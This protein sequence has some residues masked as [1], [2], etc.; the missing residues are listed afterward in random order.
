MSLAV[1]SGRALSRDGSIL[2]RDLLARLRQAHGAQVVLLVAPAGYGK[3]SFLAQWADSPQL[4][5]EGVQSV[6]VALEPWHDDPL[7]LMREI[8]CA[9]RSV[10]PFAQDLYADLVR[11]EQPQAAMRRLPA[12]A[13]ALE[14]RA[15]PTLLILDDLQSLGSTTALQVVAT[16]AEH[17]PDGTRLALASRSRPDLPLGRLRAHRALVELGAHDLAMSTPEAT[18]VLER[19]GV[20]LDA[21]RMSELMARSEGWPAALYLATLSLREAPDQAG[22]PASRFSGGD[23][24][25]AEFLRDEFLRHLSPAE[26]ELLVQSSVCEVVSAP[27]CDALIAAPSASAPSPQFAPGDR[28]ARQ[29]SARLLER[30]ARGPLPFEA[31][32]RAHERYR[33]HPLLRDALLAELGRAGP[34]LL[35]LAHARARAWYAAHGDTD[36]AITHAIAAGDARAAG[37][38][39]WEHLPDYIPVGR[40]DVL[41]VHL[42]ALSEEQI[43]ATPTL[44]L[45]AAHSA[46][47]LGELRRAERYALAGAAALARAPA[48]SKPSS[49]RAGIAAIE[50][51]VARDGLAPMACEA[52]KAHAAED[53]HSPW[54]PTFSLLLGVSAH[55]TGDRAL[56]RE[57]LREGARRG[58]VASPSIEM[59]CLTQLALVSAEERDV[60]GAVE[61]VG[62]AAA[63]MRRH[64]L[65]AY[66]IAALTYA[67]RADLLAR[68]GHVDEAKGEAAHAARLLVRLDDFIPWYSA[69]T[70]ISLSRADARLG[71]VAQA[72][73]L[74]AQ[75]SRLARRV[76][77]AT[78]LEGWLEQ[79]W[80]LVDS[81]AC[82]RLSGSSALTIAELRVL[83]FLPSHLSFPEV[84]ARLQVS[85]NTIKT[86]AHAVYR[87]LDVSSRSQ[88]V[89][90]AREI[91]LL[92][93]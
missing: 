93:P 49:L 24:V 25:V 28:R 80:E 20:K 10:E 8:V 12:L 88:A 22:A 52:A 74:L 67:V 84:G 64:S 3:T 41:Q 77:D 6:W 38:L 51:A 29:G 86:Q 81:A 34:E 9:L 11:G 36:A 61:E 15:R 33:C 57:H 87:K 79:G 65:C 21:E 4:A 5:G 66:P 76:P 54:Q 27:L 71:E 23:E 42:R 83:R 59:L 53:E 14:A 62:A 32:D 55:L 45:T 31:V 26:L 19:A 73:A 56:A 63:Q 37:E 1:K 91:G 44:A 50:A 7:A 60:E 89:A 68:V 16:V 58:A 18:A 43:A 72:R 2:R 92:E 46:L 90:R 85:T 82:T 69:E 75:A 48:R 40:N 35:V 47:S 13:A 17:L 78:V 70:R 39:M 30:L